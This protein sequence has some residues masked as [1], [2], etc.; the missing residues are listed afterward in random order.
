[1]GPGPDQLRYVGPPPSLT[2]DDA[3]EVG[4]Y[5]PR[6]G[7]RAFFDA[8]R[9]TPVSTIVAPAGSGKTTAVVE[10][11]QR[12]QSDGTPLCWIPTDDAEQLAE[13]LRAAQVPPP[14]LVI[15]DA[16]H[17]PTEAV[18]L[19]RRHLTQTPDT[20][21]LL[22][23]ARRD[24]GFVPPSLTLARKAQ[25]LRAADLR[26]SAEEAEALVRSRHPDID[27]SDLEQVVDQGDG[28]AAAL[29][30]AS[31]TLRASGTVDPLARDARVALT[32][33]NRTTMDYLAEEV[34]AEFPT[35]LQQVL[36]ATCHEPVVTRDTAI[37]MSGIPSAASL[38]EQAAEDGLLITRTDGTSNDRPGWRYH[39]LL[40]ELLHQLT[41]PGATQWPLL[42]HAHERAARHYRR[43]GD[44]AAALHH[45]GLAEDVNL[46]L[47]VLRE[48]TPQLIATDHAGLVAAAL[49]RIPDGVRD[50]LPAVHA[51]EAL[52]LRSLRRYD[53]AKSAADRALAQRPPRGDRHLDRELQADLAILEVWQARRGWRPATAAVSHAAEV[54]GCQHGAGAAATHDTTGIAPLRTAWLMIDLGQLQLWNGDLGLADMHAQAADAYAQD[55]DLPRFTCAV[56]ALRASLELATGAYQSAF[57]SAAAC[58]AMHEQAMLPIDATRRR[59]LLVRAWARFQSL[60]LDGAD[61]DLAA[62]ADGPRE[63]LDPFDVVFARLLEANLLMAR[64]AAGAARRLLDGRGSIPATLPPYAD[65]LARLAR[66]QAAGRLADLAAVDLEAEGLRTAGFRA[67]ATLV[68]A[69]E[70]GLAGSERAAIHSLE[71][72][73]SEPGVHGITAASAVV[74]R[75]ALLH[76]LGTAAEV[77]RAQELVPDMLSRI[78]PQRLLWALA[79]GSLLS[80][81]F[82]DLLATE[83]ARPDGHPFAREAHD[84]LD[85]YRSHLP[86]LIRTGHGPPRRREDD[87]AW[88]AGLTDREVDVL[89][90]LALGGTNAAIAHALFVSDN[91]VKTHLASIYRKLEVDSRAGALTAARDLRLL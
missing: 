43:L 79:A 31:T 30:L 56:L 53:A 64:G 18:D 23:I 91:T 84:A 20:A 75:V 11:A 27:A 83:A 89:R 8:V 3:P 86:D 6:P 26:F 76:R 28:W 52:V 54:L 7:L 12:A 48:F 32:A 70:L 77:H 39:P 37:M 46:Q 55:A 61:H 42:T 21:R 62:S 80:P 33:V 57:V 14:V 24:L 16:H 25:G 63:A 50:H 69:L 59:A 36:L 9:R 4:G 47:L 81:D 15:D 73:M 19:L 2:A 87:I 45:A 34:F 1:M 49:R 82:A 35:G 13:R 22:L 68:R 51:M 71:T 74:G 44:G 29:V 90:E 17:L 58:L 40:V 65:R 41:A 67:E 78:A 66:L 38:L 10:W 88:P 60:D 72:L 85:A 5:V